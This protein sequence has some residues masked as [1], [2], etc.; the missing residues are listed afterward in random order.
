M[1][2]YLRLILSRSLSLCKAD[3]QRK[4]CFLEPKP[5]GRKSA[6]TICGDDAPRRRIPPIAQS[7]SRASPEVHHMLILTEGLSLK[8]MMDCLLPTRF[9]SSQLEIKDPANASMNGLPTSVFVDV[10][11]TFEH[12]TM[13]AMLEPMRTGRR[14]ETQECEELIGHRQPVP[15]A[16]IYS[17]ACIKVP[18]TPLLGISCNA[19]PSKVATL[20][21]TI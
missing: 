2:A 7:R 13:F 9:I 19:K 8:L 21:T 4:R 18:I 1:R 20:H 14:I 16:T 12:V 17:T 6:I 3:G 10:E 15:K 5:P 11:R